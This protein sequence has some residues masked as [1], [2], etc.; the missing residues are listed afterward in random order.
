[1]II[2][3]QQRN[4]YQVLGIPSDAAQDEIDRAYKRL[5]QR[6][7]SAGTS[8]SPKTQKSL[9]GKIALLQEAYDTLSNKEKRDEHDKWIEEQGKRA[10]A[11]L[12]NSHPAD[13][14]DWEMPADIKNKS[15][16]IYQDYFG[17]S[18]KPFDL[19]PDPKYLYLSP[20]HKEVLAHLVYGI[21]ENNG[22][23]KIVG[24]VGTGKTMIC[25]SFLRELHADFSIAYIFNPGI[26]ELELLQTIN[27][28]LG[29][30]SESSSKKKLMDVLN[31]FLLKE[32][33]KGHRVVVIIDEAQDLLP[34]VL[35][36]L[37]LLSNLETET[38]KLIQ[39]VLIGQPE[40]DKVLAEEEL[41]QLKQRITIQWE[42]LPLN[43]EET[44][45]YIQHRL[46]VALGKGKVELTRNGTELIFR[47]SKGIPRMINVIADRALLIAYTQNTKNI[48]CKIIR[49]AVKDIGGLKPTVSWVEVFWKF[50]APPVALIGLIFFILHDFALPDLKTN[51]E[52]GKNI[53]K[54]I[55]QN[56]VDVS[57]PGQLVSKEFAPK[58]SPLEKLDAMGKMEAVLPPKNPAGSDALVLTQPEKLVTYLSSLSHE[59]SK[60]EA[61]KWILETWGFDQSGS[62]MVDGMAL[63]NLEMEFELAPYELNGNFKRLTN[64]NYPAI[65]EV[66]L[67]NSMGTKYL[68]LTSVEGDR[69]VFGSVDKLEMPLETINPLWTRKAII[70]WKDFESLPED[71]LEKGYEGK[72]VIWLQKNL[73]LLGFFMGR[74]ASRYGVK[75]EKA[76]R[77]FQRKNNIKDDGKFYTE[78]KMLLYNLLDIY[79]TPKLIEP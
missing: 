62:E 22:F 45:G 10:P 54:I 5:I 39:I 69:G 41:R 68:A 56:P 72:E 58:P 34:S 71:K 46:N 6:F 11:N 43:L 12:T 9:K 28:E 51:P 48:N 49:K 73:R 2:E 23:L 67:P 60:V 25:R 59:E 55:Q 4:F 65:L 63:E 15:G 32:R 50:A 16:N 7:D 17:L 64:L 21:Q 47:Y 27:A 78:S 53:P 33:K 57:N 20:K 75:T 31:G 38:E 52:G 61:A 44:R 8:R 3:V 30:P 14:K 26:D 77:N 35:E 1:M 24:E 79:P 42:L 29:L 13:L 76:V 70:F 74:E 19:T 66:A 40:L 36:Q 18:E 37:R